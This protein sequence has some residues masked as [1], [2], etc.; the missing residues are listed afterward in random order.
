MTPSEV[1]GAVKELM[2]ADN[3]DTDWIKPEHIGRRL[4]QLGIPKRRKGKA[5]EY[6]ITTELL[7]KLVTAY[8]TATKTSDLNRH[9]RHSPSDNSAA[10]ATEPSLHTVIPSPP[11]Q[12]SQPSQTQIQIVKC[13][14][15][16]AELPPGTW[17]SCPECGKELDLN[18]SQN[19]VGCCILCGKKA[20]LNEK[21]ICQDCEKRELSSG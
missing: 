13:P 20:V 18:S 12:P 5:R 14:H 17:V 16:G 1:L 15:C 2:E 19:R 11:S 8:P 3:L 10:S 4:S 6:R 21:S 7:D 9:N